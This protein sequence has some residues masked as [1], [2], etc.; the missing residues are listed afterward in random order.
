MDENGSFSGNLPS[1]VYTAEIEADGYVRT[2]IEVEVS[3]QETEVSGYLIPS[4]EEGSTGI[5][6]TWD[7]EGTD[8]DLTLFTPY[9]GSDGDMAHIGGGV[10]SDNYSN[11]ILSDNTAGCEVAYIN[12]A[13]PGS[14]KLYVNDYT[15]SLAG[16]YTGN[17]SGLNIHIYIYNSNGFVA[18]YTFPMGEKGVVWEAAEIRG[19][20]V[21]PGTRVYS[22]LEG[23]QWWMQNKEKKRLVKS[24][25][26]DA[27]GSL[28][29]RSEYDSRGNQ[30]KAI[31]YYGDGSIF[32]WKEYEYD[33]RGNQTKAIDYNSDGSIRDWHEYEYDSRGNETKE[34]YYN[35]DGN[36]GFWFEYEYEYDSVG[37]QTKK[38]SYEDDGSMDGWEEYEYDSAGNLTR[39]VVYNG[40]GHN[41]HW[42]EYEY[43]SAGKLKKENRYDGSV[44]EYEYDGA[45]NLIKTTYYD[46]DGSSLYSWTEYIYE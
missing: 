32:W 12:T 40:E 34:T 5:V 6:L 21:T 10:L 33:S 3:E 43:D 23:K 46:F 24:I 14:Y 17:L 11:R 39:V 41:I 16:N 30:T 8:L 18:E 42:Y 29:S 22:S 31:G 45:G 26:Y 1:G 28:Y 2:Y 27:D 15:D 20:T 35:S 25:T 19:G 36:I 7:G 38:I 9:Q 4:V 44:A 13:E 37:N